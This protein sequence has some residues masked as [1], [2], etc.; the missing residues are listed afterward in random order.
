MTQCGIVERGGRINLSEWMRALRRSAARVGLMV[1]GDPAALR[2][3]AADE[4]TR[5]DLLLFALSGEF[6]ELRAQLDVSRPR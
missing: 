1:G 5:R 6:Y 4:V 2:L 3:I